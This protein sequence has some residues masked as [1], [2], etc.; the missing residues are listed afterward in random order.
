MD[1]WFLDD[2]THGFSGFQLGFSLKF[3]PLA[4][5]QLT[6]RSG[7]VRWDSGPI[8]QVLDGRLNFMDGFCSWMSRWQEVS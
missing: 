8:D 2:W 7:G 5:S 6:E 4:R 3:Q 1:P